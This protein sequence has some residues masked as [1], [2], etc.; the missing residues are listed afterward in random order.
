MAPKL[1]VGNLSFTT[2]ETDLQDYFAQVGPVLA[3][4]I[5]QDRAT[6]RPR[7][8]AFVQMGTREDASKAI[9]MFH[10]RDFQGR[11]LIVTEATDNALNWLAYQ[12]QPGTIKGPSCPHD[13][14]GGDGGDDH[15][16]LRRAQPPM[17]TSGAT[18]DFTV[19][20]EQSPPRTRHPE[21]T[22]HDPSSLHLTAELLQDYV[23]SKL[24]DTSIREIEAHLANCQQCLDLSH[25]VRRF[26]DSWEKWIKSPQIATDRILEGKGLALRSLKRPIEALAYYECALEVNPRSDTA[27]NEKGRALVELERLEQALACFERALEINPDNQKALQNRGA[28]VEKLGRTVS[29]DPMLGQL[30]D[31]LR[32]W[33][34]GKRILGA[35]ICF[36]PTM[37]P[38]TFAY[39]R[40]STGIDLTHTPYLVRLPKSERIAEAPAT[41][42]AITNGTGSQESNDSCGFAATVWTDVAAPARSADET[43]RAGALNTLLTTY[44]PPL[45]R[46][47]K[48]NLHE[49]GAK[50]EFIEDCLEAFGSQELLKKNLIASAEK[51]KGRFRDLLKTSI[52]TFAVNKLRQTSGPAAYQ[53]SR[54]PRILRAGSYP[55][56]G[57][58]PQTPQR[59]AKNALTPSALPLSPVSLEEGRMFERYALQDWP[60]EKVAKTSNV[61]T[62]TV[63][64][65]T[66]R[67]LGLLERALSEL[68]ESG[69]QS[70]TV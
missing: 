33:I 62:R 31:A 37:W 68:E 13:R 58:V 70:V 65:T 67:I 69:L 32:R 46:F 44:R 56:G 11:A 10:K 41:E 21:N 27:W 39:H 7:G 34:E 47:L 48:I 19:P 63:Y 5:L 52:Y 16:S 20:A 12:G 43:V 66:H 49:Y 54:A 50:D 9:T 40:E 22:T 51:A 35:G 26:S 36:Q 57:L 42:L 64:D 55:A 45:K 15:E 38:P 60:A 30:W 24:S 1:I 61:S 25:R 59:L 29:K 14:P 17:Q 23:A 2:T 18:E 3:V 53:P 8:F 4:S 6:G 28:A